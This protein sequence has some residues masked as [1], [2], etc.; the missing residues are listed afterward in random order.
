MDN[1]S[2]NLLLLLTG[3]KPF[4]SIHIPGQYL[5]ILRSDNQHKLWWKIPYVNNGTGQ[6]SASIQLAEIQKSETTDD[7]NDEP[8]T[9]SSIVEAQFVCENGLFSSIDFDLTSRGYRVSLLRKKIFSGKYQCE[10]DQS[11]P[12]S[13]FKRPSKSL[14][15]DTSTNPSGI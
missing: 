15:S 5:D 12:I 7:S 8:W 2:K 14:V 6:L 11:D 10:E 9:T 4:L 13:F 1:P 3:K